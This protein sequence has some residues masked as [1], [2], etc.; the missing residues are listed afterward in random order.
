MQHQAYQPILPSVNKYLQY[1]W[2]KNCYEIHRTKVKSAKPTISTTPPKTYNHL[3][4][5]LK[6]QQIED[7]R[8]SRIKREN[9]MLLEKMAHIMQTNGGVDCKNDYVIKSLGKEK[10]QMELLHITKENQRILQR[11]C[12]CRPHYNI[13]T[14]HNQWLKNIELME[15]IARYP[16]QYTQGS[17]LPPISTDRHGSVVHDGA[18][19]KYTARHEDS[20]SMMNEK[21]ECDEE[22][23]SEIKITSEDEA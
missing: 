2:D 22:A 23:K 3:I 6:K 8:V 21:E 15:N 13:Q 9:H 10:R 7:E 17:Y 4:V 18:K 11:L 20:A 16:R 5:K 14:W 12:T 19:I 1:R